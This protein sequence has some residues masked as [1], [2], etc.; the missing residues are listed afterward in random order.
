L[1]RSATLF[2]FGCNER[3]DQW[4]EREATVSAMVDLVMKSDEKKNSQEQQQMDE[5]QPHMLFATDV[6]GTPTSAPAPKVVHR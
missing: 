2:A 1:L 5:N 3:I 4:D 6:I